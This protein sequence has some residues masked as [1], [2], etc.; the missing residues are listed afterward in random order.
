MPKLKLPEFDGTTSW[1]T[2]RELFDEIVHCN[3]TL[4]DRAKAQYL[5]SVLKGDAASAISCLGAHQDNYQAIY[6]ALVRRYDNKLRF[7]R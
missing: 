4:T 5:K 6:E 1:R 3:Q 7:L 2:F